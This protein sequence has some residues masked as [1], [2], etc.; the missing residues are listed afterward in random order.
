MG[1]Q[2]R[3]CSERMKQNLLLN[4]HWGLP[5]TMVKLVNGFIFMK[6]IQEKEPSLSTGLCSVWQLR[7]GTWPLDRWNGVWELMWGMF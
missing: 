1:P 3:G 5:K 6:G 4:I 2:S 7:Q